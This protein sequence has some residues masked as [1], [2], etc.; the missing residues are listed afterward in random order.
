MTA[1]KAINDAVEVAITNGNSVRETSTGWEKMKEVVHMNK[2]QSQS[3]RDALSADSRL[4]A[5]RT[6]ATPHNLAEDGYT[7]DET[8]IAISFP[9]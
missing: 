3:L 5:W 8:R 2:P 9:A 1:S 6:N 7:D 4:R